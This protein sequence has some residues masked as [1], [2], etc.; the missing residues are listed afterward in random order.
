VVVVVGGGW[1]PGSNVKVAV[2]PTAP[3]STGATQPKPI[4]VG[5]FPVDAG[6]N[7]TGPI[8]LP[9][10][11]KPG[12]VRVE[13]LGLALAKVTVRGFDVVF[14]I[15]A[16]AD[17]TDE[18]GNPSISARLLNGESQIEITGRDWDPTSL[19]TLT[20]FSD[21]TSLGTHRIDSDGTFRVVVATPAGKEPGA[22][23]IQGDGFRNRKPATRNAQVELT[24]LGAPLGTSPTSDALALT[25]SE[26]AR[27]TFIALLLV[28]SGAFLVGSLRRRHNQAD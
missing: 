11:M 13:V 23:R 14:S 25:G 22:H 2:V 5:T 17:A 1:D 20:M 6:G 21:P 26:A 27:L 18:V 9:P 28:T 12:T 15:N 7:F 16:D 8:T 19:I 3:V 4:S 24:A 10:D